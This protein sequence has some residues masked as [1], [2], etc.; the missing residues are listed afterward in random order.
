M[1]FKAE[2]LQGL[3]HKSKTDE[4]ENGKA[5][6]IVQLLKDKYAPVDRYSR[7]EETKE[8]A[9]VR[10]GK[11]EDPSKLTERCI[12]LQTSTKPTSTASQRTH[13]YQ[14]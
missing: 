12:P 1:A 13:Y 10:M 14:P 2:K 8:L 5:F 7:H 3:I 6:V 11:R 4:Y 9:A